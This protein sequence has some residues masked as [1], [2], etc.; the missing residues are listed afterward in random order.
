MT[1]SHWS[2][3]K[4]ELLPPAHMISAFTVGSRQTITGQCAWCTRKSLTLPS[5]VRRTLLRP[6]EPTTIMLA[7]SR[8]AVSTSTS[9][10]RL[11]NMVVIRPRSTYKEYRTWCVHIGCI[12]IHVKTQFYIILLVKLCECKSSYG[13]CPYAKIMPSL[14]WG[15]GHLNHQR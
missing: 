7:F 4:T 14:N 1:Q 9:P 12:E 8:L 11:P 13:P 15:V 2:W 3:Y 5:M 10:G 6:R